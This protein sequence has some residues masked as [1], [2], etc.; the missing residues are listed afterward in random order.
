MVEAGV[1]KDTGTEFRKIVCGN[2]LPEPEGIREELICK[3]AVLCHVKIF[4]AVMDHKAV[5]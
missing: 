1:A 3:I 4:L 5:V 2:T